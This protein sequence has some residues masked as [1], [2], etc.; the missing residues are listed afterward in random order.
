MSIGATGHRWLAFVVCL[1]TFIGLNGAPSQASIATPQCDTANL[2]LGYRDK[3][4]PMTGEM[5]GVYTL[6]NRG[7]V[8]CHLYGF[9]GISFYD[10]KGRVLPFKYT[11]SSSHYMTHAAPSTV[12]LRPAARAYFFVA[13]YRCDMGDA[14]VATTIRIY[15]PNTRKQLIARASAVAGISGGTISYCKGG[16]KDPGQVV[17]ISPVKANP[18]FL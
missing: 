11:R 3:I 13:K 4:S 1:A 6:T 12:T 16:T 9:P 10:S 7:K 8:T 17:D 2:S 14:M 5:G 15:P 18:K